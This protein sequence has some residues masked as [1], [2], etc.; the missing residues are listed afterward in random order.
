MSKMS[1]YEVE[2]FPVFVL[3]PPNPTG[4]IVEVPEYL[5]QEYTEIS[6]KFDNMQD[7]IES[8]YNDPKNG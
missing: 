4:K 3:H 1:V 8:L 7:K 6:Q 5:I 2:L